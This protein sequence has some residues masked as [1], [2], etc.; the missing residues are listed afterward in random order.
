[1]RR[2]TDSGGCKDTALSRG[3]Y[4]GIVWGRAAS[5]L[6]RSGIKEA[7]NVGAGVGGASYMARDRLACI[8]ERLASLRYGQVPPGTCGSRPRNK[9]RS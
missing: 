9:I 3:P 8:W 5:E 2:Q 1:M 7:R 6:K 4:R